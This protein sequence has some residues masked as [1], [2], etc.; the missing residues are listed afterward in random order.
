MKYE[1]AL[2]QQSATL[3]DAKK[4]SGSINPLGGGKSL[5][6]LVVDTEPRESV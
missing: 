2:S 1:Q 4:H 6:R 3:A 5:V